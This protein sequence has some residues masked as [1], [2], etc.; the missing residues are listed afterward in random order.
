[1]KLLHVIYSRI[2][3]V[4]HFTDHI[5]AVGVSLGVEIFQ[6]NG[7]SMAVGPVV[8]TLALLVLHHILL[9]RKRLRCHC[10]AKET[11]PVR[12][13]PHGQFQGVLRDYLEIDCLVKAGAAI[14]VAAGSFNVFEE[15][16]FIYI[17]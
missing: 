12:L 3:Q 7:I 9:Q 10:V 15:L 11:H 4:F 5:P 13:Q 6:D 17:L 1:V 8:N 2:C 14:E 16:I